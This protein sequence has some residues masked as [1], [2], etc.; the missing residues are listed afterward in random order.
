V[1]SLTVTG[2]PAGLSYS[3]NNQQII[4]TPT[5]VGVSTVSVI[6]TDDLGATTT[7]TFTI[8]VAA[9]DARFVLFGDAGKTS[10]TI[11]DGDAININALPAL[12]N[13]YAQTG[14]KLGSIG[15]VLSGPVYRSADAD[16]DICTLYSGQN[17]FKP[18]IGRYT[19]TITVYA[20]PAKTGNV[21]LT[22]I[23]HFDILV[24]N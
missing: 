22:K 4:G 5:Q 10:R 14:S 19:A 21:L 7:V 9:I 20:D 15:L 3:S 18:Q 6:A 13:A 12:L 2:L 16:G 1:A 23:I 8:S 24:T 17:G 11:S